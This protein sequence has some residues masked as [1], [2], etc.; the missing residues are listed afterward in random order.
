MK[1]NWTTKHKLKKFI[2]QLRQNPYSLIQNNTIEDLNAKLLT[3]VFVLGPPI[4][5]NDFKNKPI[6]Y[7]CL[8]VNKE[9]CEAVEEYL[10]NKLYK[11]RS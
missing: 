4:L 2:K 5:V 1:L 7:R 6:D 3:V 10:N 8:S 11:E 9:Y